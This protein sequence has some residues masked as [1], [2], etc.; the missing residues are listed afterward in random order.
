MIYIKKKYETEG[1]M[2]NQLNHRSP[3]VVVSTV[4]EE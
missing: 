1:K 4:F 2:N 3:A